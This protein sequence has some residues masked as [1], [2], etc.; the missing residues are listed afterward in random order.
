MTMTPHINV[1]AI[2]LGQGV[3]ALLEIATH[4]VKIFTM[5]LSISL[6]NVLMNLND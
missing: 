4:D 2:W 6:Q 1:Y 3:M 5:T